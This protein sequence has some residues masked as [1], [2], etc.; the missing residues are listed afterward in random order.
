MRIIV[1]L[2]VAV[3]AI[4]AA[5]TGRLKKSSFKKSKIDNLRDRA[6]DLA[7]SA[8]DDLGKRADDVAD[9]VRAVTH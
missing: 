4:W 6:M 7:G 3:G 5:K 9:R 2:A 8:T 1:L